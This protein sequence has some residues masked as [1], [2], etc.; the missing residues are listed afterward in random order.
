MLMLT[1][2][3]CG[4]FAPAHYEYPIRELLPLLWEGYIKVE[5]ERSLTSATAV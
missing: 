1:E 4:W 3:K 5:V 2:G